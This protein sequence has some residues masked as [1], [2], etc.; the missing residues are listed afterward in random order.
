ML[1]A[2]WDGDNLS[3]TDICVEKYT[4]RYNTTQEYNY[5]PSDKLFIMDNYLVIIET[6]WQNNLVVL[7]ISDKHKHSIIEDI[8]SIYNR[9]LIMT[10]HVLIQN[11]PKWMRTIK[12]LTNNYKQIS[13]DAMLVWR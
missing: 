11:S 1:V 12:H 2:T 7:S 6:E 13:D 9:L 5:K 3:T 8:K 10:D 4:L